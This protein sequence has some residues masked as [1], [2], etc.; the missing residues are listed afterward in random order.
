MATN[1]VNVDIVISVCT[2]CKNYFRLRCE[3]VRH[4][5]SCKNAQFFIQKVTVQIPEADST[6]SP[7]AAR[8]RP[9]PKPFDPAPMLKHTIPLFTF[10][11]DDPDDTAAYN[12]RIRHLKNN[13]RLLQFLLQK[14]CTPGKQE[15]AVS[16]WVQALYGPDA[17]PYLQS[18]VVKSVNVHYTET[19]ANIDHETGNTFEDDDD[20]I[21]DFKVETEK[22][23][24]AFKEAFLRE[25]LHLIHMVVTEGHLYGLDNTHL[26]QS[27]L[28]WLLQVREC[29]LSVY[30]SYTNSTE[31]NDCK[32]KTP[33]INSMRKEL[34]YWLN[35]VLENMRNK[36]SVKVIRTALDT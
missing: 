6:A 10:D 26:E 14:L 36:V 28:R 4:M 15:H 27:K 12:L 16:L 30:T 13:P 24:M 2:Q 23:S 3:E 31:Y 25:V 29:D 20:V 22:L 21:A 34:M 18:L 17:P 11:Y 19:N 32:I 1:L 7:P 33:G 8:P 9:G 35:Q 5:K